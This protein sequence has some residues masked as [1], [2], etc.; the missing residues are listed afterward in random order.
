VEAIK[1]QQKQRKAD[2]EQMQAK[3]KRLSALEAENTAMKAEN[4]QLRARQDAL[5]AA[6]KEINAERKLGTRK[7]R[8]RGSYGVRPRSI[9]LNIP[10]RLRSRSNH[11]GYV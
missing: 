5:A 8:R 10:H 4:A 1:E 6:V 3:E 9:R 11:S 7:T 2:R